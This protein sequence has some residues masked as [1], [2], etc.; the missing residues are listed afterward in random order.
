MLSGVPDPEPHLQ[1]RP[2]RVA[3]TP[4]PGSGT[5]ICAGRAAARPSAGRVG[6]RL[7]GG[8]CLA[9]ALVIGGGLGAGCAGD[10][11]AASAP[12]P[13]GTSPHHG[14]AAPATVGKTLLVAP[15][16]EFDLPEPVR[17]ATFPG[18]DGVEASWVVA[19]NQL[20][21]T[22]AWTIPPGTDPN[23]IAGFADRNYAQVGDQVDLY[24]STASPTFQ[25]VAYRMGWYHGTGARQV[26]ASGPV[27][28]VTQ[29]AC[30]LAPGVNMVSCDNWGVSLSV[31][32]SRAFVQGDYLLK[33]IGT[34]GQQS[35]VPLTV[36]DPA[37]TATYLVINRTFVEEAWNT[38][39]GYSFYQG[40]G[41]CPP[42]SGTYPVCNRAR[43]VS[44]DRP[45]SS[46]NGASD[47]LSNE[48][49]LIQFCEA[50]GLNVTYTTDVALDADPAA[51][52]HH[53]AIL[54]LGHD[55][56]WSYNERAAV[57]LAQDQGANIAFFGA[58]AVLRHVRMQASPLGPDREEVDYRDA[59]A[60]PLAAGQPDQVTGNTWSSP[61]TDWSEVPFVGELYS[62]YLN[63][64]HTAPFVV[65]DASAWIYAGTG[66]HDGDS[67]P[68]VVESDVDHLA[69]TSP[70][71]VQVL[72]HSPIPASSI[73]TNQ[74]MWA[75]FSY[76]DMTYYTDPRS[77]SGVID[78]GTVNWINAMR[79]CPGTTTGCPAPLIQK[80][81]GNLLRLFG[82]GPAGDRVPSRAN[83]QTVRPIGS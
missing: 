5:R 2:G 70:A 17:P 21:G 33:L 43:V 47:F 32:I 38:Y 62:G 45:Y 34:G 57:Q 65:Y 54:S 36:V 20:P 27:P 44:L 80:M 25:V 29:P 73:Y 51:A 18:P 77:G 64:P 11:S 19:E 10:P 13:A 48:F 42:G 30:P 69:S 53:A 40:E 23:G 22:T 59:A 81:T 35:Y 26:W 46:G 4:A 78:T 79:P 16:V 14:A 72:A 6:L 76:S 24:V 41:P 50:H 66:L 31:P 68:D 28:G 56:A 82:Q 61:P 67:L 75:G 71:D 83:W 3:S 37:S 7:P 58:A 8:L 52:L 60:D 12:P 55:E 49:P 39:G 9:V 1:D 74:G 15:S 63:G